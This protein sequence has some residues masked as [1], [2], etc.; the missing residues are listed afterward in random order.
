MMFFYL[1]CAVLALIAIVFVVWP[2]V[3]HRRQTQQDH[4]E[5]AMNVALSRERLDE[6]KQERDAGLLSSTQYEEARHELE[7]QLAV[8]LAGGEAQVGQGRVGSVMV[9]LGAVAS[10][11]VAVGVYLMVGEPAF[12]TKPSVAE[13]R[14]AHEAQQRQQQNGERPSV[15]QMVAGLAARLEEQPDDLEGWIMLGRS[16]A[17]MERW[18]D[19]V[20]AY[21]RAFALNQEDP[22][23]MVEYATTLAA[24]NDNSFAGRPIAMLEQAVEMAPDNDQASFALGFARYQAGDYQQALSLWE[25]LEKRVPAG[26]QRAEILALQLRNV[27]EKLG[28]APEQ[29]SSTADSAGQGIQVQVSLSPALQSQADP[30]DTVFVFAR[31]LEGPAMPLAVARFKVRDLPT[32]VTLTDAMAMVPDMTLT[33]VDKVKVG[34]RISKAGTP[35]AKSGDLQGEV[36]PVSTR[37]EQS[38]EVVISELVP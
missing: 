13:Q 20:N 3:R 29:P 6:L 9:G 22:Q 30:D 7:Q 11:V 26:S 34:A 36:S 24:A 37:G 14:A 35:L 17:F 8:D 2:A 28:V 33:S 18:E 12:V 5:T 1:L 19:S 23:V 25:A 16:Y 10:L 38:V 32:S 31:A 4:T 15:E 21:S 27:R